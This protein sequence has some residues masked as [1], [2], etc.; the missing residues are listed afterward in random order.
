M[1]YIAHLFHLAKCDLLYRKK[2]LS[3]NKDDIAFSNM[4]F[5]MLILFASLF[6][7]PKKTFY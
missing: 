4:K 2:I 1:Q 6:L 5:C 3:E 7:V